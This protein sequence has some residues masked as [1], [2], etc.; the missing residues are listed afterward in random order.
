[1]KSAC[2]SLYVSHADEPQTAH[3]MSHV[4]ECNDPIILRFSD[5][6]LT[7]CQTSSFGDS[8]SQTLRSQPSRSN[9]AHLQ[10]R[11]SGAIGCTSGS[12]G[13]S[14]ADTVSLQLESEVKHFIKGLEGST[15]PLLN[16][17]SQSGVQYDEDARAWKAEQ[18]SLVQ[19]LAH[20]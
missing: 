8:R 18:G 3:E 2:D 1:M 12:A 16:A 6:L 19:D 13:K 14:A 4:S 11:H 15:H 7:P 5:A 20:L 10:T 9:T 17:T